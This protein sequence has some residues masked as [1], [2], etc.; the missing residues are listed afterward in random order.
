MKRVQIVF[1]CDEAFRRKIRT[2]KLK[3]ENQLKTI[4]TLEEY[5]EMLFYGR[6]N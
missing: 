1:K 3:R 5:F 6:R 4:L 2:D